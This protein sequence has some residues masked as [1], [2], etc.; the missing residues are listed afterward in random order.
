MT[1]ILNLD[2]LAEESRTIRLGGEVHEVVGM[3][4]EGYIKIQK[5]LAELKED[6]SDAE[7]MTASVELIT[8]AVPSLKVET[9]M[10][11]PL[12]RLNLITD[13]LNAPATTAEEVAGDEKK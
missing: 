7:K 4:V 10:R 3:S 1:K 6:A 13:F 12:E 8:A 11:M 2:E 5:V 9:L